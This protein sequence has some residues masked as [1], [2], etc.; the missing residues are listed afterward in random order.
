MQRRGESY[1]CNALNL[2]G[3][4]RGSGGEELILRDCLL[5]VCVELGE[6]QGRERLS[7][8]RGTAG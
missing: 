3:Q 6:Q 1:G 7:W 5:G 4:R 2:T 8:G